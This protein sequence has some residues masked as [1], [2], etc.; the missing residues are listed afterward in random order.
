MIG[1]R[2]NEKASSPILDNCIENAKITGRVR[3]TSWFYKR[4]LKGFFRYVDKNN[5]DAV[6]NFCTQIDSMITVL[7][8]IYPGLWDFDFFEDYEKEL[9]VFVVIRFPEFTITNSEGLTHTIKELFVSFKI[10]TYS[11]SETG[12][13]SFSRLRGTRARVS[14]TERLNSYEHSHLSTS[15]PQTSE[16]V[17]INYGF[18]LGNSTEIVHLTNS[19]LLEYDSNIFTL[20]LYT[21]KSIVEWESLEGKPYRYIKDITISKRNYT[22][23]YIDTIYLND[24]YNSIRSKITSLPVDFVLFENKY[25]II[26]NQKFKDFIKKIV[27]ENFEENY[28]DYLVKKDLRNDWVRYS[29]PTITRNANQLLLDENGNPPSF[30]FRGEKIKYFVEEYNGELPKISAYRVHPDI[31]EYTAKQ[32]ENEIYEKTIRKHTIER[33]YQSQNV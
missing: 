19:L 12:F 26:R 32:L 4:A 7:N 3:K 8:E 18:C 24:Y 27:I 21:I 33:Y 13:M 9:E 23:N 30:C 15:A 17:F 25:K 6:I 22:R 2:L 5:N 20:F 1:Y 11:L 31:I 10:D 14:Y 29:F 16:E 28:G